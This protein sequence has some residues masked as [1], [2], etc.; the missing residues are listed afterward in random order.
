MYVRCWN[1]STEIEVVETVSK[2]HCVNNTHQEWDCLTK[3]GVTGFKFTAEKW[4][5]PCKEKHSKA[6]QEGRVT[7][8]NATES[9]PRR[10]RK[11]AKKSGTS[12]DGS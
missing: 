6:I 4:C 2:S 11:A 10:G 8:K 1:C 9:K 5:D 7:N 3:W 12:D